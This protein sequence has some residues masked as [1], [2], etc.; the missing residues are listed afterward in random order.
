[1]EYKI[2]GEVNEIISSY[3]LQSIEILQGLNFHQSQLLKMIEF[4]SNSKYL[5]GQLD[6][7]GKEKPFQNIGNAICDVENAAV[8]IDTKDLVVTADLPQDYPKSFMLQIELKE[9]MKESDFAVTLNDMRDTRT[10]YGGVVV[11][12]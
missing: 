7:L 9:W 12:K 5:L 11:K 1:M 8:D 10:R 6:E 2:I 3:D 4:Y